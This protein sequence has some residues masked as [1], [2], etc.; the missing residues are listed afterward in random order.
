[1]NE[2]PIT[3]RIDLVGDAMSLIEREWLVTNGT[4]AYAMGTVPGLNTRR[5]HGLCVA[6]T[7]PPVG[8][9]VALNQTLEH[10]VCHDGTVLPFSCFQFRDGASNDIVTPEGFH[11][12]KYFAKGTVVVWH[13]ERNGFSFTRRLILHW[14]Q[15]AATLHYHLEGPEQP[16]TLMISPMLTLR[17][18][19]G[20]LRYRPAEPFE[21]EAGVD[22]VVVR[23]G[24][25][26]VTARSPRARFVHEPDWWYELYYSAEAERGQDDRE[27]WYIP[28][29]FEVQLDTAKSTDVTLT[30]CLGD[31]PQNPDLYATRRC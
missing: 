21:V 7:R 26:A 25:V 18:F 17:D 11:G 20:L 16:V 31:Q 23:R 15:Q 1:M 9:V 27:D 4:G 14:M 5:Y 24:G 13:Y 22:S 30:V 3:H 28:G 8:R 12:L 10:L 2:L 29:R 19:H 6:V